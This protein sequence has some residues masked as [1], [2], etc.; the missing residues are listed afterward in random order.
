[1]YK[2]IYKN[3]YSEEGCLIKN[4]NQIL[5]ITLPKS[6][7]NK[8]AEAIRSLNT[9]EAKV[10]KIIIDAKE[11]NYIDARFTGELILLQ[12]KLLDSNKEIQI[13]NR[14]YIFNLLILLMGAKDI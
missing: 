7:R 9:F 5:K 1:M 3:Y 4:E 12:T 14:S 11:T 10:D 13:I 8:A 6:C 2:L